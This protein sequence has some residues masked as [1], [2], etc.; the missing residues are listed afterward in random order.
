[1]EMHIFSKFDVDESCM[2]LQE[3]KILLYTEGVLCLSLVF[4][5]NSYVV[6]PF[7]VHSLKSKLWFLMC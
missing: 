4:H 6:I 2:L 1:M 5:R 7:A 3:K